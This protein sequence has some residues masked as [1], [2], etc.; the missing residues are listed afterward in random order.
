[1]EAVNAGIK[2]IMTTHGTSL[3]EIK[4]RPTITPILEMGI[5][6]RFIELSRSSGPGSI[7]SIKDGAG[8]EILSKARV[9]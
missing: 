5:F 9:M 8:K 4:K 1:M 2:L 3:E 7:T 6:Q